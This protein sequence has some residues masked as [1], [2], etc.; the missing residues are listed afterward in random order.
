MRRPITSLM[1]PAIGI[2]LIVAGGS[3]AGRDSTAERGHGLSGAEAAAG[4]VSLFDGKTTYGWAGARLE[5]GRLVGGTTT[6]EF[7]DCEVRGDVERGGSLVVGGKSITVDSGR[8][9]IP[10]TGRRGPIRL[11]DRAVIRS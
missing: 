3:A 11:G 4:W 5:D 9:V 8:L 7:G 1:I 10:S 2:G 6:T